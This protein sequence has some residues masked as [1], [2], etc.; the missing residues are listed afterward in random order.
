ML[1]LRPNCQQQAEQW[2]RASHRNQGHV[3][4]TSDDKFATNYLALAEQAAIGI[5]LRACRSTPQPVCAQEPV[6]ACSMADSAALALAPSGPPAS[7]ARLAT[8]FIYLSLGRPSRS[9]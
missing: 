2:N 8:C 3:R 1:A 9:R 6:M 7:T 4:Y 5:W